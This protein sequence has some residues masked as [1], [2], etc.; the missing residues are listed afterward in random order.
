M[1]ETSSSGLPYPAMDDAPNIP[2]DMQALAERA[3][4]RLVLRA[5]DESDRNSRY[6]DPEPGMLVVGG[7]EYVWI[8]D[9]RGNWHVIHE[10]LTDW[11]EMTLESGIE[12][13]HEQSPQARMIGKQV[14]IRGA[15]KRKD[16]EPMGMGDLMWLPSGMEPRYKHFIPVSTSV[17]G[18]RTY[19]TTRLG[20]RTNGSIY[21]SYDQ[22]PEGL[23]TWMTVDTVSFWT[24]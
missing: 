5:D 4:A 11:V 22:D 7:N 3:D 20:V 21:M 1:P 18:A 15:V 24:D 9:K 6:P 16:D 8:A 23:P 12:G 13:S 2:A 17:V 14:H 19:N 10:P